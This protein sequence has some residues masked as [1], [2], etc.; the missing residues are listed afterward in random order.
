MRRITLEAHRF[1]ACSCLLIVLL[2]VV[3]CQIN[4]TESVT[5]NEANGEETDIVSTSSVE[6]PGITP[7]TLSGS[8]TLQPTA[9]LERPQTVTSNDEWTPVIAE[10][11]G[12]EMALVPPGC[13]MM[14]PTEGYGDTK[15]VREVCFEEPYWIDVYEVTHKQ[16]G[17]A[18][19]NRP[20]EL[21]TWFEAAAHCEAR[22]VRLPTEAEWEYAARG[23]DSLTYP[24]GNEIVVE[25][26]V[27][28]YDSA[29]HSA[30]V[31][32]KLEGASWVGAY[33]LSGNAEEWV[34]DWYD[35]N[36][37]TTLDEPIINPQGPDDGR[38][39]VIRGGAWNSPLPLL[40]SVT[41]GYGE[42]DVPAGFRCARA[43]EP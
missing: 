19:D 40:S 28:F 15:K 35:V 3:S 1:G 18:D 34:N 21:A 42:P 16:F 41:R 25:N 13:F 36:Y 20:V 24:W 6:L 32:S 31:G 37:I 38:F 11:A 22:G 17:S 23:P 29:E 7:S 5:P 27:S 39:R 33:D 8:T 14:G 4:S 2:S 12:V 9:T 43:W 26:V 30:D 10:F